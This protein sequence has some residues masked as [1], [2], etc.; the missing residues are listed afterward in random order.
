MFDKKI[1]K[2]DR[3][4]LD[5]YHDFPCLICKYPQSEPAH[6]KSKGAG[7]DDVPH[8][9]LNLCHKCHATTHKVGWFEACE[10]LPGLRR[11]LEIRGWYFEGKKLL[12]NTSN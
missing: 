2:K 4:L 3:K 9:L 8:N 6:I 5:K 10:Q 12:F 1:R 7:G 11:A